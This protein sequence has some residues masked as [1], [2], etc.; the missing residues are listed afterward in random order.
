[1]RFHR[2]EGENAGGQKGPRALIDDPQPAHVL[3]SRQRHV[4]RR[5][6]LP[7]L[8]RTPGPRGVDARLPAARRRSLSG[9]DQPPPHCAGGGR[10][11]GFPGKKHANQHG[12]PARMI[13]PQLA[14]RLPFLLVLGR[15][16]ARALVVRRTNPRLALFR[17]SADQTTHRP[18]HQ[19]Q[20]I[21]DPL[22][23]PSFLPQLVDHLTNRNRKRSRHDNSS[24]NGPGSPSCRP[25]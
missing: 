23:R 24:L 8:V 12:A 10:L 13:L 4:F 19:S 1:M 25:S 6:H 16:L 22:R 7:D 17:E 11:I 2:A 15:E 18:R 21:R 20:V 14:R 3:A 5:V 9:G